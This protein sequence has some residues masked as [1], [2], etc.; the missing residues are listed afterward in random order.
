MIFE[1][2]DIIFS[3]LA[4]SHQRFGLRFPSY[5]NGTRYYLTNNENWLASFWTGL[6][7]LAYAETKQA[8]FCNHAERLLSTFEE[9]LTKNIRLNHD[10]GFL[11]T[12]SARA[13]W[14]LTNSEPAYRLAL[15][16]A[17]KLFSRYHFIGKYIQAWG[18]LDDETENGR[19]IID[20]MLNI[21]LL[22]WAAQQTNTPHYYEAAFNHAKTSQ[23]Y[24]IRAD[25]STYHT[26]F[27]KAQTGEPLG[28]KTHQGHADDSL[29]TRGQS[30]AIY[31]FTLAA[32]WTGDVSF[33]ETAR[34]TA[35]CFIR[36][37]PVDTIPC[38][39]L[40]L[41]ADAPHYPDS[42]AAAIAA[43]GLLRLSLLCPDIPIYRQTAQ[44][45]ITMLI[46]QCFETNPNAAGL[47]RHGTLHGISRRGID[48]YQIFGDY[49]FLEALLML[50]G[51]APDF[52]GKVNQ[53]GNQA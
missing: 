14:Q 33:L 43:A 26:F 42:S 15:R 24:L 35:D 7:W 22:F 16:G 18:E 31:G 51:S 13:Q 53:Q 40:R 27:I 17:E 49:F 20:G 1:T 36:E 38:W 5:G 12:L 45:I 25:G 11:F 52:W 44:H 9:R 39:D 46:E 29:W 10:I 2:L 6:L 32:E 23:H 3:R 47:L 8:T 48:T 30:W 37:W 41:P 21:P 50:K 4:Q 34:Q 28:A 19:F